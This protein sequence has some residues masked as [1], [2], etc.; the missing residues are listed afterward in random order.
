MVLQPRLV[1]AKES[2]DSAVMHWKSNEISLR[3][4]VK[5]LPQKINNIRAQ[6][7]E[8]FNKLLQDVEKD[9]TAFVKLQLIKGNENISKCDGLAMRFL[10]SL[11]FL[12]EVSIH[13]TPEQK[14]IAVHELNKQVKLAQKEVEHECD[15]LET[16]DISLKM[17]ETSAPKDIIEDK[18]R[19]GALKIQTNKVTID[20]VRGQRPVNLKLA[21][22]IYLT[23]SE[24]DKHEPLLNGVD[25]LPGGRLIAID[26]MNDEL[27]VFDDCLEKTGSIDLSYHPLSVV[28]VSEDT[29]A[30]T[31]A[32]GG[33][34]QVELLYVSES[35]TL[36]NI[37]TYKVN[38][39]YNSAC[40]KDDNNLVIGTFDAIKLARILSLSG[41]EKDFSVNF[42]SK[43]YHP[44]T[45]SCTYIKE[46]DKVI[47]SD[48]DE[49]LLYIYD[50]AT[51]TRVIVRDSKIDGPTGVAVGPMN[52]VFVCCQN[53]NSVVQISPT[54]VILSSHM[55]DMRFPFS[56]CISK[57]KTKLAVS[58]RRK[59]KRTLQ[60]FKI[61]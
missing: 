51:N 56:I 34:H 23:K 40:L 48:L 29:V 60:V 36:V 21:K 38:G 5:S 3:D 53:T 16:V 61:N 24:N 26:N 59:E 10:T 19:L 28:A 6:M 43:P 45:V 47:I 35:S 30:I 41:E 11:K 54:G 55:L 46:L 39:R 50:V 32:T 12:D 44:D 1:I 20:H 27:L 57:D 14:F 25:F 22:I 33:N 13:G 18:N 15:Q 37:K 2:C 9:S 52:S 42:H 4:S 31:S 8:K 7:N 49:N 58:N 17:N